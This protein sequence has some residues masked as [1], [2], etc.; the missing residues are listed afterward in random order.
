MFTTYLC[1][2]IAGD[3]FKSYYRTFY[4]MLI[5]SL[6]MFSKGFISNVDYDSGFDSQSFPLDP[7]SPKISLSL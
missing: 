6:Q 2:M 5:K 7:I 1:Y 4:F 3:I